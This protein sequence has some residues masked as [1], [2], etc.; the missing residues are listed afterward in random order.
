MEAVARKQGYSQ[1]CVWPGTVVGEA[2]IDMFVTS[3]QDIFGV[4][5]QYLE[6]VKTFPDWK[7]GVLVEGTGG[8]NDLIFAVHE[9][10]IGKFAL[11]RLKVGIRWVEDVMGTWNHSYVLYPERIKEYCSWKDEALEEMA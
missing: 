9:D 6:E 11:P 1:V 8:R 3:M 2:D 7:N 5:V 4:R 10:D